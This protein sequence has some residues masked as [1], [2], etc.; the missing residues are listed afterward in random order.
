MLP[1]EYIAQLQ[2]FIKKLGYG[3]IAT[4]TGRY[5]AMDRDKRWERIQVAYDGLV[6]GEGEES[7]DFLKT[8]NARYEANETDEFLK[9]IILN[10]QGLVGGKGDILD[11]S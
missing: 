2:D 5:Y 1:V 8:V 3:S 11:F 7:S 9:P 10:K 4:A 6:S